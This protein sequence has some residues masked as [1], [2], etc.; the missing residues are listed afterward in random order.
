MRR[1]HVVR[2]T[3]TLHLLRERSEVAR[4]HHAAPAKVNRKRQHRSNLPTISTKKQDE[5]EPRRSR[6]RH[7][8]RDPHVP[9]LKVKV[10]VRE[11]IGVRAPKGQLPRLG[12]LESHPLPVEQVAQP[13]RPV[14]LVDALPACLLAELDHLVRELVD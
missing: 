13:L 6:R 8:P 10:V 5:Q 3:E 11:R 12:V 14:P 2:G 9:I 4:S 7:R 1:A